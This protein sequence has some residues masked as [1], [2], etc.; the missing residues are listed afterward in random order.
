M[1]KNQGKTWILPHTFVL[2]PNKPGRIRVVLD[3]RARYQGVC[4]NDLLLRGP[5]LLSSMV[6]VLLRSREFTVAITG[7]IEA[8]Y[9]RI[10]VTPEQ[11][12]LLRFLWRVP[13]S[14]GPLITH[15]MTS[16]VFGAR[17]SATIASWVL[18]LVATL[19]TQYPEVAARIKHNFYADNMCDSFETEAQAIEFIRQVTHSL[20]SGGFRLTGFASSSRRVVNTVPPTERAA[21]VK[22]LDL[23]Q[24]AIEYLFGSAWHI[25][26]DVYRLRVHPVPTVSTRREM[27]AAMARTFDPLGICLPVTTYAKR[28]F[29][30]ASTN[31]P[32][33]DSSLPSSLLQRWNL[34]AGELHLLS[35]IFV[36]RCFRPP[37]FPINECVFTL[38]V[39]GDS[40]LEARGA[41]AYLRAVCG[42]RVSATFVLA[43]GRH[44]PLRKPLTIP[45]LELEAAVLA[46]ELAEIIKSELRIPINDTVFY[47]DST[48]TLCRIKSPPP[49]S[50]VEGRRIKRILTSST[51]QQWRFVPSGEN[52]A[53]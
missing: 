52:P 53:D 12:S 13:G 18:E 8:F 3:A 23:D 26:E 4:L 21:S 7:D 33:W 5:V 2:Y 41:V 44:S 45:R 28:L 32:G 24:P 49:E 40:S 31:K 51:A 27:L 15:E 25:D 22:D 1:F 48:I 46:V 38:V 11:R 9:H 35:S 39:F 43:K 47:S 30:L 10:S 20:A 17:D 14:N 16:H 19:C 50:S 37:D 42:D 6:G 29:Q 36:P 34:W